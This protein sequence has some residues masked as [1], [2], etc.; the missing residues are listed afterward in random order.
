MGLSLLYGLYKLTNRNEETTAANPKADQALISTY[1]SNRHHD[2][3]SIVPER[4]AYINADARDVYIASRILMG[5]GLGGV[6][7]HVDKEYLHSVKDFMTNGLYTALEDAPDP[8]HH[9]CVVVGDYLHQLQATS[10][11]SGWNY[12]TNEVLNMS[13]GWTKYKLGSTNFNDI[14]I[15]NSAVHAMYEMPEVYNVLDN[16]CQHFTLRL[17][18]KILRDGRKKVKLLNQTYG[19]MRQ[20]PI[21]LPKPVKVYRIGEAPPAAD[22]DNVAVEQRPIEPAKVK[23]PKVE[24]EEDENENAVAVDDKNGQVAVVESEKDHLLMIKE[25]VG[26]M[27]QNTPLIK[28]GAGEE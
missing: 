6:V 14:A 27:I 25:A 23:A 1:Q 26:I 18:D 5:G 20:E 17:L 16:N 15:R 11:N 9:W 10:L 21:A 12:Y 22:D 8:T 7:G 13:D 28:E 4:E 3:K 19:Q 2:N 24:L